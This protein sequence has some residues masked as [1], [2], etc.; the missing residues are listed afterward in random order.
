MIAYPVAANRHSRM[1]GVF[2]HPDDEVFCA[3]GMLA[4]WAEAGH[5]T[6]IVSATRG[7]AG[8]IQDAYAATRNTL[9]TV[10]E[11]E[12]RAACAQL[13]VR[14]VECLDYRDGML[15]EVDEET[16]ARD[17]AAYIREFAPEI[18]VTFGPDGGY[19]H[20]DHIAISRA[21]TLACQ[22]IAAEGGRAPHLYYSVFPRQHRLLCH[23]LARWLTARGSAFHGSAAFV[24]ALALLADEASEL[25]YTDDA[26]EVQWFPAGFSIVEQGERGTSL[27]LIVSGQ[28]E[29]IHE[30]ASG[31]RH[32]LQTLELGQFFGEDALARH[33]AQDASVVATE[34][35]TCLVLSAQTPTL[36]DGRGS[37]AHLSGIPVGG[38]G[39]DEGE[40]DER[41]GIADPASRSERERGRLIRMDVS[42]CLDHK[43][44]A[45]A[46]HRTQFAVEP[47][48][49]PAAQ[50]WD[51]MG[52][53]YFA[54]VALSTPADDLYANSMDDALWQGA[55]QRQVVA[56]PA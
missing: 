48:M 14:H 50:V 4:Q 26:V 27:Y 16:L 42:A 34:T 45:L 40:G 7:E 5:E 55:R 37:D 31:T 44:A 47:A 25:G 13:G 33:Q 19:G 28:A 17:I 3:G 30:D 18:V 22:Q 46:A 39:G 56:V 6:M 10:R 21:T 38:D 20:P 54:H 9:G 53:E 35:T 11:E 52:C 36:F 24:R 8:Q 15:R 29:V 23:R 49:F 32:V 12:L 1:M 51:L 2:A 43:I 41:D